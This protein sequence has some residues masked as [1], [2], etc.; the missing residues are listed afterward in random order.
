[1]NP[2]TMGS[3]IPIVY[4]SKIAEKQPEHNSHRTEP[5]KSLNLAL[6]TVG[7]THI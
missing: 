6:P 1:M 5:I 2:N 4:N 3:Q 7:K